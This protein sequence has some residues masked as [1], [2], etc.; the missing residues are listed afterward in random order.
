ML[1]SPGTCWKRPRSE[2]Q[3]QKGQADDAAEGPRSRPGGSLGGAGAQADGAA[4]GDGEQACDDRQQR[5][6][7]TQ[8]GQRGDTG[9]L[10]DLRGTGVLKAAGARDGQQDAHDGGEDREEG[11]VLRAFQL[12]RAALPVPPSAAW[13]R[14]CGRCL[15]R[16]FL[17]SG[18]STASNH[19]TWSS[20]P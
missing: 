18:E 5:D 13:M 15:A 3:E 2:R 17:R 7:V 4:G 20:W 11:T 10:Q 12:T 8:R 1:P 19:P 14:S 9:G 16:S 6:R